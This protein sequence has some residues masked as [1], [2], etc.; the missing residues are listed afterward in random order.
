MVSC[1][2]CEFI[3]LDWFTMCCSIIELISFRSFSRWVCII[4]TDF[5]MDSKYSLNEEIGISCFVSY[6]FWKYKVSTIA[7]IFF[8]KTD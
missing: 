3:E 8:S 2:S 4:L 1:G 7:D 6:I 5:L